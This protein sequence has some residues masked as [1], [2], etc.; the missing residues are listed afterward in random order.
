VWI[1][2]GVCILRGVRI[3]D[4]VVIGAGAVVKHDISPYDVVAGVPAKVIGN[5]FL[6]RSGGS[7][8]TDLSYREGSSVKPVKS[9]SVYD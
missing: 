3:A 2:A 1:G 8:G 9:R 7:L 5:R 6:S 4:G